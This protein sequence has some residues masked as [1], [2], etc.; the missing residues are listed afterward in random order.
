MKFGW[1]KCVN[2]IESNGRFALRAIGTEFPD[3]IA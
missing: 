1:E 3:F 2:C